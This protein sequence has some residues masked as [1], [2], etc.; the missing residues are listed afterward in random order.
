MLSREVNSAAEDCYIVPPECG[1]QIVER[2]Y[3]LGD[4]K[5]YRRITDH[6][7]GTV[8]YAWCDLGDCGCDGECACFDPVNREPTGFTWQ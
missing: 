1:G 5:G 8:D 2:A 6:A 4:G 7:D 3:C